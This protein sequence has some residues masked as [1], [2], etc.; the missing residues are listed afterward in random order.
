MGDLLGKTSYYDP[1]QMKLKK[2]AITRFPVT[3][4]AL[5]VG[6]VSVVLIRVL[7]IPPLT[8]QTRE[9]KKTR[10]RRKRE[11]HLKL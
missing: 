6:C 10:R 11:R 3:L 2:V 4:Q 5:N 9:L 7:Q 1:W 8:K